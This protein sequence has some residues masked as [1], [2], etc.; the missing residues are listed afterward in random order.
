MLHGLTLNIEAGTLGL[1]FSSMTEY[2]RAYSSPAVSDGSWSPTIWMGSFFESVGVTP[3]LL[4]AVL[5][6]DSETL[7]RG[8]ETLPLPKHLPEVWFS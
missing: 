5:K 1:L 4:T 7:S 8:R 2:I 6:L 3:R